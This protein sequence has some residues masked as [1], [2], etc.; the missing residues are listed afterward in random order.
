LESGTPPTY[1]GTSD[2]D[3]REFM[4]HR[5]KESTSAMDTL[6]AG[7]VGCGA[8]ADA[9]HLP[10]Y[11]S[12]SNTEL[13]SV[14]EIDAKRR[15]AVASKYSISSSYDDGAKM[16]EEE[17]LDI[18]SICT[19]PNTHR[20]LFVQAAE[21]G[22]NIYCEKPLALSTEEAEAMEEA[23]E[24]NSVVTQ[25]G[26][27]IRYANNYRK[28]LE[29]AEQKLLGEITNAEFFCLVNPPED[30]W[31]YDSSISGG[32]I[33]TENFPHWLDFYL[34]LF[35]GTL[36]VNDAEIRS[37]HTSDVEDYA[38]ISMSSSGTSVR[39]IAKW[40]EPGMTFKAL[41]KNVLVTTEGEFEFNRDDLEGNIRGQ[42]INFKRGHLPFVSIGPLFQTW[43]GASEDLPEKPLIDFIQHAM[44]G[45]RETEAPVSWGK[46]VTEL[47]ERI[48]DA[49]G[50]R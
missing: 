3:R 35:D 50:V 2:V 33:L 40:I 6:K 29:W 39:V 48:Y 43:R 17:N 13:V 27:T 47:R 46:K 19:P 24:E 11:D 31:R 28:I 41:K 21:N 14:A 26:Y 23:A 10:V 20:E 5:D 9:V 30:S 42:G 36:Q 45:D 12:N 44:D 37:V 18:V 34:E 8:I 32:G 1:P 4:N 38:S 16:I 7:V 22:C 15:S 25:V 49:G